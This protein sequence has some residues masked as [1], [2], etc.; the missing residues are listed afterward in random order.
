MLDLPI[1]EQDSVTSKMQSI[2]KIF[3]NF[4]ELFTLSKATEDA[5]R[6]ATFPLVRR[7]FFNSGKASSRGLGSRARALFT[8][9]SEPSAICVRASAMSVIAWRRSLRLPAS[10]PFEER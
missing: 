3:V 6:L 9:F 8:M 7:V 5:R 1:Q 4:A 2:S 10:P